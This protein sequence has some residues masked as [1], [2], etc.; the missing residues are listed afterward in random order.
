MLRERRLPLRRRLLRL[1]LILPLHIP[2]HQ[3]HNPDQAEDNAQPRLKILS[4][5]QKPEL[6]VEL[7]Q[8]QRAKPK[9]HKSKS[10][11]I[12]ALPFNL[13]GSTVS[14]H[15]FTQAPTKPSPS[16]DRS[17]K[18]LRACHPGVGKVPSLVVW[19]GR[20]LFGEGEK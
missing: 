6:H 18:T 7:L 13:D 1:A 3:K 8:D 16:A 4:P 17:N 5:G 12:H 20:S 10:G 9:N 19:L 14:D 11:E 2:K 15:Q